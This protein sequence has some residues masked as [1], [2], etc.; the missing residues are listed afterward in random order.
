[1]NSPFAPGPTMT[2]N[3]GAT[4]ST[5][6]LSGTGSVVEVQNAG[7]VPVFVKFGAAA[8]M[9]DYPIL[10]GQSKLLT[11]DPTAQTLAAIAGSGNAM[12]YVTTGEGM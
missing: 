7:S 9:T 4:S 1:M 2:L 11:R 12:I 8:A 6:A 10:P 3:A 5:V